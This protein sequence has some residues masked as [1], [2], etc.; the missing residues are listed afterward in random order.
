MRT[1]FERSGEPAVIPVI[2]T[3]A[4]QLR[5]FGHAR[6]LLCRPL[7]LEFINQRQ[8][9]MRR[10]FYTLISMAAFA[11]GAALGFGCKVETTN[12]TH[13][14]QS[15]GD[16]T[17][18]DLYGDE[19]RFCVGPADGCAGAAEHD[20]CVAQLPP[21]ECYSP[22]GNSSFVEEDSSCLVDGTDDGGMATGDGDGDDEPQ[23]VCGDGVVEG[24]EPCDDGNMISGDACAPN[25][26]LPGTV[27]WNK[28][29]DFDDHCQGHGVVIASTGDLV[30]TASCEESGWRL[31]GV[32][33]GGGFMWLSGT[34]ASN[35]ARIAMGP[36]DEYVIGGLVNMSQGY[37]RYYNSDGAWEWFTSL[38]AVSSVGPVAIDGG[39]GV[40]VGGNVGNDRFVHRYS[41]EGV[42]E[43]ATQQPGGIQVIALA[44][45]ATGYVWSLRLSPF[46]LETYTNA[47]DPDW[48]YSLLGTS[49]AQ[50]DVAVDSN[51]NAYVVGQT[52]LDWESFYVA[53][54]DPEGAPLWTEIH[55][56]P[57][58]SEV[59]YSVAVMPNGGALVAG[60]TNSDGLSSEADGLLSW[61]SP[62]GAHLDDVAF[63]GPRNNDED[64]FS[65]VAVSNDGYAIAVGQQGGLSGKPVLWLVKVAI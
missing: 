55:D 51:D 61:Y 27:I 35:T 25:C 18:G 26:V 39:G 54:F 44:T 52:N 3:T 43:W 5:T 60:Y 49:T 33:P 2:C 9:D 40:I 64:M 14:H 11:T 8:A 21:D 7:Q 13:C 65:D 12:L 32:R 23:P 10:T 47:G 50:G 22:C 46:Q 24:E 15:N 42:L 36:S 4:E 41:A 28:V 57:G 6:D 48:A 17:C 30:V 19:R 45:N 20:G 38:D 63:D 58:I 29:Y 62:D 37:I 31:L 1:T 34:G 59:G 16:Q 53:K 56:D